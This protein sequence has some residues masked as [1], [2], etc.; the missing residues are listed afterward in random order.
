MSEDLVIEKRIVKR[1]NEWC[2][3]H[4]KGKDEGKIIKCFPTRKQALSMHRAIWWSKRKDLTNNELL[5]YSKFAMLNETDG[6]LIECFK[7]ISRRKEN[8]EL[9]WNLNIKELAKPIRDRWNRIKG[10]LNNQEIASIVLKS[11]DYEKLKEHLTFNYKIKELPD[12]LK[13]LILRIHNM[14]DKKLIELKKY[15]LEKEGI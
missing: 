6:I 1:G 7:E 2:V 3:T 9:K 12:K 14:E 11:D 4:G 10:K 8:K 15:L 13:S 5:E